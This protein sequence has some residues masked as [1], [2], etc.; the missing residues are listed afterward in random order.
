[1][2][3]ERDNLDKQSPML[4][5]AYKLAR[6]LQSDLNPLFSISSALSCAFLGLTFPLNPLIFYRLPTSTVDHR[7][8]GCPNFPASGPHLSAI[9]CTRDGRNKLHLNH[10][11]SIACKRVRIS[12]KTSD[13]KSLY[14]H[15][16]AHSFPG[17]PVFSIT[18]QKLTRGGGISHYR[19]PSAAPQRRAEMNSAPTW[20]KA[21]RTYSQRK[22]LAARAGAKNAVRNFCCASI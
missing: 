6:E 5:V 1:M 14:L 7:G 22:T 21:K 17:S 15:T 11:L 4:S 3:V 16:H 2:S 9:T 18:S 20:E 8:W 10:L 12:L 19:K 13:F